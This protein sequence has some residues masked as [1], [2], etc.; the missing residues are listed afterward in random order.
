MA[1]IP[2]LYHSELVNHR[3]L[4]VDKTDVKRYLADGNFRA[5]FQSHRFLV[6]KVVLAIA[7][8]SERGIF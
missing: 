8:E 2:T 5:Y 1:Q 6:C 4:G 3:L 7:Y